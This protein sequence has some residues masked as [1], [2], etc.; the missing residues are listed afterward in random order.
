MRIYLD[1]A[2]LIYLVE[3]IAPYASAL[4]TRLTVP[5]TIQVC[6]E[7]SRLECRVKPIRDGETALLAAFDSYFT[8]IIGEVI[9]L[10]RQVIDQATELRARYDFKTPDAIHLAAA[11]T[12]NCDLF[13]TNDHRLN[14]CTEIAVETVTP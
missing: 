6:S 9:P 3:N 2:P 4:A 1:S 5:D 10:S 14:K 11:I 7:L 13:L 8:G 12:S